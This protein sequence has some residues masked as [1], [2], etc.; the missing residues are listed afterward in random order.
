MAESDHR[1]RRRFGQNFLHDPAII[2]R[3]AMAV[4]PAPGDAVVEVGPGHGALTRA[5]L[6]TGATLDVI[7][8]DRDLAAEL[9]ATFAG[10]AALRIHNVDALRFDFGALAK[11]RGPLRLVGNLPYNISTP[12]LFCFLAH[13][14]SV[15]DMHLMLQKEVADR[16]NA[17]P[18]SKTYGRLSVMVQ[19]RC[20]V[21]R[22]FGVGPGAFTPAPKVHSS[23]LRLTPRAE[24]P[25]PLLDSGCLERVVTLAFGQRRKTLRNSLKPCLPASAIEA[26]GIDAGARPETLGLAEFAS[27][28]NALAS[29]SG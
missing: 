11:A 23:V 21:E 12:L 7:E 29:Q 9:E 2:E 17:G 20:Q 3:I 28:A 16:I 19:F 24:P 8:I 22:L 10:N 6:D 15:Q 18:G 1:A 14:A 5:L 4:A 25:S 26:A 13:S 27:L